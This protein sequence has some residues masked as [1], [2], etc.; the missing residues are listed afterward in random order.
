M[1]FFSCLQVANSKIRDLKHGEQLLI[2]LLLLN[3]IAI[4]KYFKHVKFPAVVLACL[5][6]IG[7]HHMKN[8][9]RYI[10]VKLLIKGYL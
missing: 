4:V 3:C 6:Y 2:W 1:P 7:K 10:H 5:F 9:I 8:E